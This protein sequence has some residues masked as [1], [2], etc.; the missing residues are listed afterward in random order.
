MA[1][2]TDHTQLVDTE[3]KTSVHVTKVGVAPPKARADVDVPAPA[4]HV[5][6]VIIAPLV[7]HTLPEKNCVHD[8][9]PG[10]APPNASADVAVPAPAKPNLAVIIAVVAVH[11][12]LVVT[13]LYASVHDTVVGVAPPN[14]KADV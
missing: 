3:L 9:T 14:A 4:R 7:A 8:N 12:Q 11:T 1:G 6:A 2:T 5:L 10:A 13:A